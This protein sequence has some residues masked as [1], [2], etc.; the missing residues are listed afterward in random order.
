MAQTV[1]DKIKHLVEIVCPEIGK[2]LVVTD[3]TVDGIYEINL[4]SI[5]MF[6]HH[7]DEPIEIIPSRL[8]RA[9]QESVNLHRRQISKL[10]KGGGK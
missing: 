1:K 6:A 2:N 4:Y 5:T 9:L 3:S 7:K 8:K 10:N